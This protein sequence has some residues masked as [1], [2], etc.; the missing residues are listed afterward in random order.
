MTQ[1]TFE[2][3]LTAALSLPPE[4][5]RELALA[6]QNATVAPANS[7]REQLIAELEHLREERAFK[8]V[9]SLRNQ[10][11]APALE[12]VSDEQLRSAIHE[13]ACEWE[14]DLGELRPDDH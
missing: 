7:L 6:L 2:Q 5:R 1:S 13:S 4:Q 14:A 10:Y 11:P 9:D 8:G 12:Y 3:V